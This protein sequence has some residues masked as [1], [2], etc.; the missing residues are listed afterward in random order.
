MPCPVPDTDSRNGTLS[1]FF[2]HLNE[3]ILLFVKRVKVVGGGT[4]AL[5]DHSTGPGR[6]LKP[7]GASRLGTLEGN[8][9]SIIGTIQLAEA[10]TKNIS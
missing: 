1:L 2:T 9:P 7:V 5:W 10:D 4:E 8:A 6:G 3:E